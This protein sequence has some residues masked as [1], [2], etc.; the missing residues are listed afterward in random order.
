MVISTLL[1]EV[2]TSAEAQASGLSR[3]ELRTLLRAGVVRQVLF[4][5]YVGEHVEDSYGLRAKALGKVLPPGAVACRFTAAWLHGVDVLPLGSHVALPPVQAVVS[6][7]ATPI[8]R[9]GC[10]GFVADLSAE[11]VTVVDGVAA[12]TPLRT[13]LDL[14]R[15]LKRIDAIVAVDALLHAGL[16]T[17]DEFVAAVA[18]IERLRGVLQ[19]RWVGENAEPKSE[20]P[21]E[22]RL[23]IRLVDGGLPRPKAQVEVR[24]NFGNV[25]GRLDLAYEEVL[26]GLEFDGVDPHTGIDRRTGELR[27]HRDRRRLR[28]L[29]RHGWLILTFT[30]EDVLRR[31]E[32]VVR[33]AEAALLQR[34]YPPHL[35]H[36]P[37]VSI[38]QSWSPT[39]RK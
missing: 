36:A 29:S 15:T 32:L 21:M 25:V 7:G 18:D 34:G 30:G 33:E 3:A 2:F 23:R 9:G 12:T 10:R 38:M 31:G 6:R 1:D 19:L 22:T 8:R 28:E 11:D 27:F 37:T 39:R 17:L 24:D 35:L 20:S 13:G 26:L 14:G 16:F 4:G 5:V